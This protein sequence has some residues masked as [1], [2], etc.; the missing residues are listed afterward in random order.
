[1]IQR[2]LLRRASLYASRQYGC[3]RGWA[4]SLRRAMAMALALALDYYGRWVAHDVRG[5]ARAY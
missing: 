4:L 2:L 3:L 1:M 5:K